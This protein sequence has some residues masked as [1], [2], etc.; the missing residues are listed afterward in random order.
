L[1]PGECRKML[2]QSFCDHVLQRS[3]EYRSQ[4]RAKSPASAVNRRAGRALHISER[5]AR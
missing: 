4:S 3:R 1:Q 2:G 5:A